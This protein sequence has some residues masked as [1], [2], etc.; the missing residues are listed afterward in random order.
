MNKVFI[1]FDFDFNSRMNLKSSLSASKLWFSISCFVSWLTTL[2][3]ISN[4]VLTQQWSFVTAKQYPKCH[5]IAIE[6][7][8]DKL[9]QLKD[10]KNDP[11]IL[12]TTFDGLDKI[13]K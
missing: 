1:H 11:S 12:L 10:P 13:C 8:F 6:Q 2:M 3:I 5:L 4:L 9:H 7:C